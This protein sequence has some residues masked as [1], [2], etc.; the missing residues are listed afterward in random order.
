[1]R[2]IIN[3]ESLANL[4]VKEPGILASLLQLFE[5]GLL[6]LVFSSIFKNIFASMW[7]QNSPILFYLLEIISLLHSFKKSN[8]LRVGF[9]FPF[10]LEKL[11]AYHLLHLFLLFLSECNRPSILLNEDLSSNYDR[12]KLKGYCLD[13]LTE[14]FRR[15]GMWSGLILF[16]VLKTIYQYC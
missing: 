2:G 9:G 6:F 8:V 7:R 1:M 11:F 10:H 3:F 13:L 16:S 4:G 12:R 5:S 15:M 14:P